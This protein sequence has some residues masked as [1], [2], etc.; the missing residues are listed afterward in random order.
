MNQNQLLA[1]GGVAV[2][3]SGVLPLRVLAGTAGTVPFE[4]SIHAGLPVIAAG[5]LVVVAALASAAGLVRRTIASLIAAVATAVAIVMTTVAMRSFGLD[6][7]NLGPAAGTT[8][9][10]FAAGL[11]VFVLGTALV[12]GGVA[13]TL[14]RRN[15]DL[16]PA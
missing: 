11:I 16:P 9:R 4:A 3:V 5:S 2:A 7:V 12:A 14:F 1:L 8:A 15:A 6:D 10:A 13:S